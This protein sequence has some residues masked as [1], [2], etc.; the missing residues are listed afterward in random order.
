MPTAPAAERGIGAFWARPIEA[1][2]DGSDGLT[3]AEAED[4]ADALGTSLHVR[5]RT[6]GWRLVVRQ[7]EN[8]IVLLLIGATAL[9]MVLGDVVCA[10]LLLRGA[11]VALGKLGGEL[12]PADKAFYE[13]KVAA[14]SFFAT[15]N[16]PK[17]AGERVIA[18]SVDMS[19]MDLDEAAF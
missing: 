6:S 4:R 9:S 18:E 15:N 16:L 1:W 14:A 11:E 13:G 3:A 7:V 8:P 19:L 2:A 12:S 10:W 17:I 5:R